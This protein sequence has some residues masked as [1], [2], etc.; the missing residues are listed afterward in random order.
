[1][2]D[3]NLAAKLRKIQAE[4]IKKTKSYVSFSYIVNESLKKAIKS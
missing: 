1:M 2:L 3:D 4:Q